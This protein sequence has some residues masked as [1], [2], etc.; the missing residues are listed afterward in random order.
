MILDL[1]PEQLEARARVRAFVDEAIA[2]EAARWDREERLPPALL[3]R[4]GRDGYFGAML[5]PEYGGRGLDPIA[6]GLLHEEVGRGC[7][8]TRSVITVQ[9]MVCQ[10]LLRWGRADQKQAFLPRLAS[11]EL[12]AAFALTEPRVGSDAKSV[13][14]TATP[15]GDGFVLNG[16]KRWTTCGAVADL[17]LVLARAEGGLSAFL[18]DRS[19]PGVATTPITGLLGCRAS[20]LADV[21]F[22]GCRV[23]GD[24]L[25]GRIGFGF[26]HVA[27]TALDHGRYTI[28]WGSVGIAQGC[29]EAS[30]AYGHARRQFGV[31][32]R[33]HQLIQRMVA[34]MVVNVR[35][36]R[37]LCWH[38]GRLKQAG[39]ARAIVETAAAKYFASTT[40]TKLAADAVQIHGAMGCR[41]DAAVQR[42]LRDAK[43]M[44]IIEGSSQIQQ[45][46]IARDAFQQS[47]PA[48]APAAAPAGPVQPVKCVVWDLDQTIWRGVLLED[49]HVVPRPEAVRIVKALDERGILQS[50]ASRNDPARAR[51]AL[52]ALGLED[53][54]L[55]PQ[56]GWH[57]KS[58]SVQQIAKALNIALDSIAF[59][60]DDP[61]EREEVHAALPAVR[62]FDGA[63]LN[64]FLDR[65]EMHPRFIT[66]ESRQR[67]LMYLAD[68]QRNRAEE[69]FQGPAEAFLA[70]LG[71][72][73]TIAPAQ[74]DDLQRAEE[75]TVRTHQLNSTGRTYSYDELDRFRRAPD[76]QLLVARLEDRFGSYGTIG[77]ALV[78][79]GARAWTIKLLLMSC[80]V[81]SRGVGTLL[82][83]Q[84]VARA[85]AAGV[86]LRAEFVPTDVNRMMYV[87]YKFAGF[88]ETATAGP[89][90]TLERD[91]SP[92]PAPPPW[93]T[94]TLDPAPAAAS[95]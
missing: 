81:M 93:V 27:A 52:A 43:I 71:M 29:L 7:S 80:R 65:P 72:R 66:A 39:D 54:F 95:R 1:T 58:A 56:I 14:T 60:D 24:R 42:Y 77:L 40:A 37:L 30:L 84:I 26:S 79:C 38:A 74:E 91:G 6:Y 61:F 10:A 17:I 5:P 90:V 34:D 31:A 11:G 55:Y 75:L 9:D 49:E 87:T 86:A 41:A 12:Q 16:R 48:P 19:T 35:A 57:A 51:A 59:A 3:A 68:E 78:E 47:A 88:T 85:Q 94:L 4:L 28:A 46:T 18:V 62:C 63:D 36:A 76:H 2:G 64:G 89:L 73:L 25:I 22:D 67:R 20:M 69:A 45:M 92:A 21:A 53:Y 82:L 33:E 8:S 32:L 15:D 44:E 83:N 13:E 50:I 70:S 23:P